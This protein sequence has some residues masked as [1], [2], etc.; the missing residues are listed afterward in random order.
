MAPKKLEFI[1][2][3]VTFTFTPDDIEAIWTEWETANPGK[4]ARDIPSDEFADR[5]MQRLKANA[6]PTR[7]APA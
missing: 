7:A 4:S 1:F 3:D 6:K 5:C 2:G